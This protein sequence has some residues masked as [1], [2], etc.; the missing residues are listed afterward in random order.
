MKAKPFTSVFIPRH[1]FVLQNEK[2]L[3]N[4]FIASYNA[5]KFLNPS[6]QSFHPYRTDP[7]VLSPRNSRSETPFPTSTDPVTRPSSLGEHVSAPSIHAN[8]KPPTATWE[9]RRNKVTHSM[10]TGCSK[11]KRATPE[12]DSLADSPGQLRGVQCSEEGAGRTDR[13]VVPSS[14]ALPRAEQLT[15]ALSSALHPDDSLQV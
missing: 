9:T 11:Q 13:K 4:G 2:H 7:A 5:Q 10:T 15:P 8:T 12:H 1:G 3:S 14:A 6:S